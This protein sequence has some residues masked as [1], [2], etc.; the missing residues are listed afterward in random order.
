MKDR[1][2]QVLRTQFREFR[3]AH[4]LLAVSGGMDSMAMLQLFL[5]VAVE[6]PLE[7]SCAHV[8][9]QL[10]PT[11]EKDADFV[12]EFA[13]R[14]SVGCYTSTANVQQYVDS[15]E[16]SPEMAARE[17]R[18][19]L[20]EQM[21]SE[22]DAHYICTAH[23]MSDQAETVLMRLI[24]GTGVQGIMGIHDKRGV[25][26]RPLLSFTREQIHQY[27]NTHDIPYREDPSN[28]DT[29]I[30]RNWIRHELL[31][32]IAKKQN[33]RISAAL[34]RFSHIQS[35][36][37]EYLDFQTEKAL[38]SLVLRESEG[39][40]IL[41]IRGFRNYFTVIQKNIIQTCLT[42]LK[43]ALRAITFS[44]MEQIHYLLTAG[45][46]GASIQVPGGVEIV[47]DRNEALVTTIPWQDDFSAALEIPGDYSVGRY[48]INVEVLPHVTKTGLRNSNE[49]RAYFD[50]GALPVENLTWRTWKSGDTLELTD[51]STK[52]VS[53]IW[54]D[55]KVPIWIKHQ[56]PLLV[57]G[58]DI[59][60]IPG[61]KRSGKYWVTEQTGNILQIT[62]HRIT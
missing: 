60:W 28:K 14:H 6:I 52:K 11:S 35:E 13:H 24:N 40:I 21:R 56:T 58:N 2:F 41:D 30:E 18:Y 15:S 62:V 34:A 22:A 57:H 7:I 36:V 1:F 47:R 46:S 3:D 16:L 10:R 61:V 8:N 9:H 25:I 19:Q 54:I 17:L 33:P 26:R 53:D 39:Q 42:E 51:G 59:L 55:A 50:A 48:R 44:Q 38:Q 12:S 32:L 45:D 4:L 31:P 43:P 23:T 37:K 5:D 27:V 20:L 29:G 49:F